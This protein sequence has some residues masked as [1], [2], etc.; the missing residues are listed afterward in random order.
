MYTIINTEN[1]TDAETKSITDSGADITDTDIFDMDADS[2]PV[3]ILTDN[4]TNIVTNTDTDS[5]A[6]SDTDHNGTDPDTNAD[7]ILISKL[8][9]IPLLIPVLFL[10]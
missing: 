10:N 2:V 1:N 5:C 9:L 6:Y 4:D 8:I 7:T 3:L